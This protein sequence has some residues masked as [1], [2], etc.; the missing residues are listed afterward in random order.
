[1]NS[2]NSFITFVNKLF[3][4]LEGKNR[5]LCNISVVFTST[6]MKITKDCIRLI[7]LEN[8]K[9]SNCKNYIESKFFETLKTTESNGMISLTSYEDEAPRNNFN[10]LFVVPDH[11]T[12][13]L[14]ANQQ[15]CNENVFSF[16]AYSSSTTPITRQRCVE[17]LKKFRV[18]LV[19]SLTDANKAIKESRRPLTTAIG[20]NT[21]TDVEGKEYFRVT[22][23]PSQRLKESDM[24]FIYHQLLESSIDE[25][26]FKTKPKDVF[27]NAAVVQ[28][29]IPFALDDIREEVLEEVTAARAKIFGPEVVFMEPSDDEIDQGHSNLVTQATCLLDMHNE[30]VLPMYVPFK[31]KKGEQ[32]VTTV[33]VNIHLLSN[34]RFCSICKATKHSTRDFPLNKACSACKKHRRAANHLKLYC[35]YMER[36]LEQE[37]IGQLSKGQKNS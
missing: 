16:R 31:L 35:P 19:E 21:L 8:D 36:E 33:K 1:M 6:L 23:I 13:A 5:Y 22:A 17:A 29:D 10:R 11:F 7:K 32:E 24:D 9:N 25:V 28:F 20:E 37:I 15:I 3:H 12:R 27:E 26:E 30:E 4:Q 2:K 18:A 34:V 14:A